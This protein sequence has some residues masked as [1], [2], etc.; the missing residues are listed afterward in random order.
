MLYNTD[1]LQ[2][3]SLESYIELYNEGVNICEMQPL[4]NETYKILSL[5][6]TDIRVIDRDS[7][8]DK[9]VRL[10]GVGKF[11]NDY[12]EYGKDKEG[13]KFFYMIPIQTIRGDIVS[14]I[15]RRVLDRTK[16]PHDKRYH[17]L[18]I[19]AS[20]KFPHMYGFY[21]DFLNYQEES[22]T[23]A[24]P[25]VV[26]EGVKD[27]I[28]L[29]QYYPYTLSLNTS[30][31][32]FNA[33]ILRNITNKILYVSDNDSVGQKQFYSDRS[34]L[35]SMGIAVNQVKLPSEVKDAASLINMPYLEKQFE[36]KFKNILDNFI[37]L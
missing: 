18:D 22:D 33:D 21:K 32:G 9:L 34:K 17:T 14:F 8:Y 13:N 26:C 5:A 15:L 3:N 2:D 30:S 12:T 25:I 7:T 6:N 29:K 1:I 28:Y 19:K 16:S 24:K 10:Q 36:I 27:C 23:E 37:N 4:R 20:Y 31:I 35:K 11:L